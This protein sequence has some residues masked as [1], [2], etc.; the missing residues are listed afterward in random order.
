MDVWLRFEE[1]Y[2]DPVGVIELSHDLHSDNVQDTI[3][4][5]NVQEPHIK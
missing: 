1:A 2:V 4:Q 3:N 5:D